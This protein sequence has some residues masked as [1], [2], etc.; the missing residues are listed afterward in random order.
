MFTG[1]EPA[2]V[3]AAQPHSKNQPKQ[4]FIGFR[5]AFVYSRGE[6]H[7]RLFNQHTQPTVMTITRTLVLL[8]LLCFVAPADPLVL[9]G[10]VSEVT[11]GKSVVVISNNRKLNII[12]KGVDAP[13]L[14]QEFGG[15]AR[16]HLASLILDK[17]VE[18]DFSELQGTNVIG[19]VICN[20]I[21]I[22]LQVIRDGA[23]WYDSKT[24]HNLSEVERGVYVEAEQA[25]RNEQRGLWQD[26]SPMPPWEWRRAQAAKLAGPVTYKKR[27]TTALGAEDLLFTRP[28]AK[29]PGNS[30][31]RNANAKPSAKPL[32]SPGQDFDYRSYLTQD[33]ISVVYFYADWCPACRK[34]GPVMETINARIPDMQVLFMNIGDWNTPVSQQHGITFVPYLKIY[35]RNGNLII[36]G[37]SANAWLQEA[38]RQRL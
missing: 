12:L 8:F 28:V 19:K 2:A 29:K 4:P 22:G 3:R 9:R 32:N 13:E 37:K 23:A 30:K 7:S 21:D 36:E 27:R 17:V 15:A 18:V 11:D 26:G 25:A 16:A 38:V 6:L 35:D 14:G 33:R 31:D 24:P 1:R 20:R 5:S 10:V 34:L